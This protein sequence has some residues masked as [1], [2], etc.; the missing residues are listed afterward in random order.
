MTPRT[1][2]YLAA[3]S[4]IAVIAIAAAAWS[5]LKLTKLEAAARKA[6]AE[7]EMQRARAD[8]LE[9]ETHIYKEKAAYLERQIA[10]LNAAARQQD[11]ELK[12][13]SAD[14]DS[15]RRA[16]RDARRRAN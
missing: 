3:A 6:V 2:I 7:S 8:R 5:H 16:L 15:A 14:T 13:L 1:R 9:T 10:E 11:E 4:V 12:K